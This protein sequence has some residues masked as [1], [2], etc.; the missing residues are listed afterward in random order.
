MVV[1]V[2]VSQAPPRVRPNH[3][4]RDTESASVERLVRDAHVILGNCGVSMA[5]SK[6]SKLVRT[7]KHR[8]EHNGF[9]FFTFLANAIQLDQQSRREAL[10]N[11]EI[12][13]VITY[14]DITGETAAR[15]VD[16]RERGGGGRD[17]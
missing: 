2:P 3:E 6:V 17:G 9:A 15:N 4:G 13:R 12:V 5:P 14:A 11:P 16:R 10:L 1:S 8:V 7:Y